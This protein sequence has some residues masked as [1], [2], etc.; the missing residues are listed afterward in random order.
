MR[1]AVVSLWGF[2]RAVVVDTIDDRVTGLAAE[3]AFF[4]ALSLFP[5]LLAFATAVTLLG[6]VG[7]DTAQ[8]IQDTVLVSLENVLTVEAG[9]VLRA[10]RDIFERDNADVFTFAVL[11]ALWSGSRGMDAVIEAVAIA[12]DVEERRSWV[13]RRAIALGLLVATIVALAIVLSMLVAGPLLGG[14]RAVADAL[15]FGA[16]F[17]ASWNVLRLPAAG[18]ALVVW[19]LVVLHTARP[20][21]RS[22]R[23]DLVGAVVAASGVLAVSVGLR[24]YLAT[25]GRSN[26]VL[27]ALGGPLILLLWL[28]LLGMALLIGAEVAQQ[29]RERRA[30][31]GIGR[32]SPLL[33]GTMTDANDWN[34]QIIE[35]FR[36]NGGKVGGRFEGA[37][38]ILVHHTGAKSGTERVS[39]LVYQPLGDDV[40]IFASKG[41]APTNPDWF[42]NL[43]ANPETVVEIGTETIPVVARVAEGEERERIWSKQK[44]VMPGFA[45]YE[46]SAGD[47]EIPVVVLERR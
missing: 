19:V 38:M 15:G 3:I 43:V 41:G 34:K 42:H 35:E 23:D 27:G 16:L 24:V 31:Q 29:W 47:R 44:K 4:G 40:A 14:G 33:G 6:A 13:R 12:S 26:A 1:S 36:A 5:G 32:R 39:P 7:V 22:W 9:G 25:V 28:F 46:Q 21:R 8:A 37:P 11:L 30:P 10:A 20:R 18:L 2:V 45:D 17:A